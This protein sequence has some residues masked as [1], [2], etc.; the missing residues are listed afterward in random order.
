[1]ISIKLNVY[2]ENIASTE[3]THKNINHSKIYGKID[4]WQLWSVSR[5]VSTE[6]YVNIKIFQKW[7]LLDFHYSYHH[8]RMYLLV[9]FVCVC[10]SSVNGSYVILEVELQLDKYDIYRVQ[11]PCRSCD[12]PHPVQ[13]RCTGSAQGICSPAHRSDAQALLLQSATK[14]CVPCKHINPTSHGWL[15]CHLLLKGH[16]WKQETLTE[17]FCGNLLVTGLL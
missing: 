17:F 12:L 5:Q 15:Q 16:S 11:N 14:I 1:M 6:N 10:I 4:T 7:Y 8:T 13:Y 9:V 3:I 2:H